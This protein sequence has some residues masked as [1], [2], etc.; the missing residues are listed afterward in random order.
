MFELGCFVQEG[1]N[2]FLALN[3]HQIEIRVDHKCGCSNANASTEDPKFELPLKTYTLTY[4][5]SFENIR[6]LLPL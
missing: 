4:F 2:I 6:T 5:V 3:T 1:I